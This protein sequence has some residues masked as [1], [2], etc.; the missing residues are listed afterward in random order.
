MY[1]HFLQVKSFLGETC[2]ARLNP[3]PLGQF[4]AVNLPEKHVDRLPQQATIVT[5]FFFAISCF[6]PYLRGIGD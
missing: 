4:Q 1:G 2:E 5:F 3:A 6:R